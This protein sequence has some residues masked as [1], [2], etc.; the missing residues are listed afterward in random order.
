MQISA[1]REQ[2]A[3]G[4][5]DCKQKKRGICDEGN[6]PYINYESGFTDIDFHR[7][8]YMYTYIYIIC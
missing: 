8:V 5:T 1:C 7:C 2:T 4:G 6:I 3:D